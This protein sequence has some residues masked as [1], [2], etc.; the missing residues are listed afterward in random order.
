LSSYR[1]R[2]ERDVWRERIRRGSIRK[3]EKGASPDLHTPSGE[4]TGGKILEK[5]KEDWGLKGCGGKGVRR[6]K[7]L[8]ILLS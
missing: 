3:K 4:R 1:V 5:G 8:G 2:K 6:D 7:K